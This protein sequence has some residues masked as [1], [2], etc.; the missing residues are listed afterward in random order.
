MIVKQKFNI[1][2]IKM[3]KKGQRFNF[4]NLDIFSAGLFLVGIILVSQGNQ[5]GWILIII[6]IMKQFSGR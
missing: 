1:W 5:I 6:G 4:G 3:N 2:R